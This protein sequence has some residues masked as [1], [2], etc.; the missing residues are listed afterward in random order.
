MDLSIPGAW[1]GHGVPKL[2]DIER[3]VEWSAV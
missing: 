2:K 3:A 1:L